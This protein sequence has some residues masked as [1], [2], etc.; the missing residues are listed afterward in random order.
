MA[1]KNYPYTGRG[2]PKGI[3]NTSCKLTEEEV[4]EIKRIFLLPDSARPTLRAIGAKYK[5]SAVTV[6]NIKEGVKWK[7][8]TLGEDQ[9]NG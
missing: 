6:F 1:K 4:R 3:L 9:I 8:I 7:H 2:C 5:V